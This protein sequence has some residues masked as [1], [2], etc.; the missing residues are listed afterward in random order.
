VIPDEVAAVRTAYLA[1]Q[2]PGRLEAKA[3]VKA[4]LAA[5]VERAP[6]RSVEVRIPPFAAVQAVAGHTH[7]RGTPAAVVEMDAATWLSLACGD[8]TW[9]QGV[10][11]GRVHASG[12]RSDLSEWLPLF[13]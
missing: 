2:T 3:A 5:L 8:L 13:G 10:S 4:C 12:E 7:R 11:S 1:G 9:Q 6:G